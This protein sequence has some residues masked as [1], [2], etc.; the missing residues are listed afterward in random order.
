MNNKVKL[1]DATA[2]YP[3]VIISS[4]QFLNLYIFGVSDFSFI[5]EVIQKMSQVE[6]GTAT[7]IMVGGLSLT[8]VKNGTSIELSEVMHSDVSFDEK[9]VSKLIL[10]LTRVLTRHKTAADISTAT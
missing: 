8:F 3:K 7:H 2:R 1:D 4:A 9:I 6:N 10:T 5:S